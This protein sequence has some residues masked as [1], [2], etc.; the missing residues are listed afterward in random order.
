VDEILEIT[1]MVAGTFE[2]LDIPYLVGG[3][4]ASSLHGIP[5]ATQ[6]VD[7]VARLT[8]R[9]VPGLVAALRERFY[10]DEAAIR[11]AVE[12]RA[13]F[14]LIDLRTLLK[15]DVF[16]AKDDEASRAQMERRQWFEIE[17]DPR[18]V[19]VVA[20]AEDVVAHKL[21]WYRLGDEVSDRQWS[22]AIGVLRVGG[23]RLDLHYL[24]RAATLLGVED[25]LG[26]ALDEAAR[27]G[28]DDRNV[29]D[30]EH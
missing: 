4:L 8:H 13:S 18:R 10:L 9:D 1:L 29:N 15:V 2:R 6:D 17:S 30:R 19:L 26:R 5:R 3:S 23:T 22:D 20:S 28:R 11:E 24:R 12:L 16:V 27:I 21:Y 14:N 7:L 25:L